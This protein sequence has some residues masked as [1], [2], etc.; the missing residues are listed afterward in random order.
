MIKKFIGLFLMLVIIFFAVKALVA[1]PLL[2]NLVIG[3]N[4]SPF[5]V[6]TE[7]VEQTSRIY[8]TYLN[9]E[10]RYNSDTK[11]Q[12]L[13]K[14]TLEKVSGRLI[15]SIENAKTTKDLNIWLAN[16]PQITN[17]TEYI[18]FGKLRNSVTVQQYVIDMNGGDLSLDDFKYVYI[19]DGNNNIYAQV[20]LK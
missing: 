19:V 1:L 13:D 20:F 7:Y 5:Q 4:K 8:P 10:I 11:S 15:M 17:Q 3:S 14:I 2:T 16:Q 6:G 12:I 9:S 18:D